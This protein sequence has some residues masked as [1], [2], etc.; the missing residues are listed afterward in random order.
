MRAAKGYQCQGW[1]VHPGPDLRGFS[2]AGEGVHT[3]RPIPCCLP[4]G[5]ASGHIASPR[6]AG[7]GAAKP[8]GQGQ[9]VRVPKCPQG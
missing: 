2:G 3:S 9:G 7:E 5:R 1:I 8:R 6:E 4:T